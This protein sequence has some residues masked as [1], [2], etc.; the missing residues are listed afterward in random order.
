MVSRPVPTAHC[1]RHA[2]TRWQHT[3]LKCTAPR[4]AV[5]IRP[6]CT[7]HACTHWQHT[8]LKCT[9]PRPAVRVRPRRVRPWRGPL[10]LHRGS[11]LPP[12]LD[13]RAQPMCLL[14][15]A[16]RPTTT[17]TAAPAAAAAAAS[18][19][20]P[21]S[22]APP[23]TPHPPPPP[24]PSPH[25][26]PPPP[27]SRGIRNHRHPRRRRR[28]H[29]HRRRHRA[30]ACRG[31]AHAGSSAR[32]ARGAPQRVAVRSSPTRRSPSRSLVE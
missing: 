21:P 31:S 27:P 30:M 16:S 20:P 23:P 19:A 9:A 4:P 5:R 11:D 8:W 1:T 28:R 24:P 15:I 29:R 6:R 13:W 17:L 22:P 3:W 12:S 32:W 2:C 18:S 7:R 14:P 26:Q 25:P 10:A